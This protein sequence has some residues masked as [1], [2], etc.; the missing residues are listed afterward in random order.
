MKAFKSDTKEN[1]KK[2]EVEEIEGIK[3]RKRQMEY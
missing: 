2:Y 3:E 1:R